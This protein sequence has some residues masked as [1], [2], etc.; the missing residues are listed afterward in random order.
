MSGLLQEGARVTSHVIP[1]VTAKH[2]CWPPA[3]DLLCAGVPWRVAQRYGAA[4]WHFTTG[5]RMQVRSV[6][7]N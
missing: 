2:Q 5:L 3:V 1:I 6:L 4:R 7:R